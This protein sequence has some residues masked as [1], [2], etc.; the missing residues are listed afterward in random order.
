[1]FLKKGRK[2][3]DNSVLR[4]KLTVRKFELFADGKKFVMN[5]K[6]ENTDWF[7]DM[8]MLLLNTRTFSKSEREK[9]LNAVFLS[10]YILLLPCVKRA[11][12]RVWRSLN[13]N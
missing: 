7:F 12:R 13:Y 9:F 1:M 6:E 8:K 5:I 3:I 2:L 10:R 4:Q 11:G